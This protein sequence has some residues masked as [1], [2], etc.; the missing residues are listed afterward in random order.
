MSR[1]P[2]LIG[3]PDELGR[4]FW[5]GRVNDPDGMNWNISFCPGIKS[6]WS[7]F[8]NCLK[9]A[10]DSCKW[11]WNIIEHGE[12]IKGMWD[13]SGELGKMSATFL[14]N[15]PS[16]ILE[17]FQNIHSLWTDAPIAWVARVL[18]NFGWNCFTWPLIKSF[19]GIMGLVATPVLFVGGSVIICI[20]KFILGNVGAVLSGI[21]AGITLL[22]GSL[23]TA[24]ITIGAVFNR[25]PKESDNGTYGLHII[26]N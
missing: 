16:G 18:W 26:E 10:G 21:S 6:S 3:Y 12:I 5:E 17:G 19:L 7:G 8:K 23:I 24:L 2:F 14:G 22:G 25:F 1:R 13:M 4:L 11:G 9:F 15:I 20:G